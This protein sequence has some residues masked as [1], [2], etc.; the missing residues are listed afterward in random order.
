[1]NYSESMLNHF[2]RSIRIQCAVWLQFRKKIPKLLVVVFTFV[3]TSIKRMVLLVRICRCRNCQLTNLLLIPR[4][5][6][7][8]KRSLRKTDNTPV[9]SSFVKLGQWA[10]DFQISKSGDGRTAIS[11]GS[12]QSNCQMRSLAS[13]F[14]PRCFYQSSADHH[15]RRG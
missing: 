12:G 15:E 13:I 8:V 1:M 11:G 14:Q 9:N 6:E 10:M 5:T 4:S 3:S 7:H 2:V